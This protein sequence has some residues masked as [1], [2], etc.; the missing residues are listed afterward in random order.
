[1][2]RKISRVNVKSNERRC[3]FST[4]VCVDTERP[5]EW[6]KLYLYSAFIY[7]VKNCKEIRQE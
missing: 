7:F 2:R 4:S 3:S 6:R 5:R 1:M